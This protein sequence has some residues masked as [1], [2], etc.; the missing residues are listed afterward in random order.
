MISIV[1]SGTPAL[2][3]NAIGKQINLP[4]D[5]LCRALRDGRQLSTLDG[6]PLTVESLGY[7][8]LVTVKTNYSSWHE[9]TVGEETALQRWP[10]GTEVVAAGSCKDRQLLGTYGM[11]VVTGIRRTVVDAYRCNAATIGGIYVGQANRRRG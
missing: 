3:L 1:G 8:Q 4:V 2:C 9:L 5:Y 7:R 11:Y 6:R 10:D